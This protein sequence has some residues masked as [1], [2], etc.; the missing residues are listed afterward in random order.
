MCLQRCHVFLN[1]VGAD[2]KELEHTTS[3]MFVGVCRDCFKAKG[4]LEGERRV[5][6]DK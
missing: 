4:V 3:E 1:K 6:L 2:V 5:T